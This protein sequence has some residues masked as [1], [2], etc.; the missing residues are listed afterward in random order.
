MIRIIFGGSNR[1]GH[2]RMSNFAAIFAAAGM[3][4]YTQS[5]PLAAICAI[6]CLFQERWASA[7]RDLEEKRKGSLG[8]WYWLPYGKL[9]RHRAIWSHGLIVGTVIRLLYGYWGIPF[10]LL[11]LVPP[12]G[13]AWCIGALANDVGHLLLD[14]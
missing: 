5:F 4:Y 2:L 7:D 13:M 12:V 10:M 11:W 3:A 14:L 9:V 8:H 1:S 6:A